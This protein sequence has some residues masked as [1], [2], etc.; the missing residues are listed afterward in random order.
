MYKY[1]VYLVHK[2]YNQNHNCELYSGA[3]SYVFDTVTVDRPWKLTLGAGVSLRVRKLVITA[4]SSRSEE[5]PQ[6]PNRFQ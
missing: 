4:G 6:V 5:G 3:T 2:N 1:L